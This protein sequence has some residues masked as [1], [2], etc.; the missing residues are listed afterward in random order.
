MS[1][2]KVTIGHQINFGFGAILMLALLTIF[3]V[4]EWV[5]KP[6]LIQQ[7]QQQ[8]A[9]A[10]AGLNDLLSSNLRQVEMLTSTLA[11]ASAQLPQ[12]EALFKQLFPGVLSNHGDSMIAGGGIWPEPNQ[13]TAGVERR[14]FFWGRSG[15]QML[16]FDGYNRPDGRGYHNESWYRVGRD[17]PV[18]RC[19]WS[20]PYIDPF[21]KTP[22]LTCT[23]PFSRD[24]R[25]AGVATVDMMLS[26]IAGLLEQYGRE[27]GGYAF[28]LDTTGKLIS[29]PHDRAQVIAPDNALMTSSELGR[30]LPW[31]KAVLESAT[32][33]QQDELIELKAD[34]ILG[35]AA[36]VN[37]I[38]QPKTGWTIGLVVPQSRMTGVA[39]SMGLFLMFAVGSLLL[40]VSV[41]GALFFR[42]LL[43][44][45]QQTT[46]Q[47]RE[48]TQGGTAQ[49]LEPGAM[50]EIGDLRQ[51]V[52]AYGDKLKAL[53]R[54]LERVKDELVQSEK[55]ASLGSLVSGVAHELNTPIGNALMSS[56]SIIDASRTISRDIEQQSMTRSALTNYTKDVCEG[57]EIIERN[58]ARAA[59]L[60]GAF[61][62][63]A[64]D[65][66]GSN[67]RQFELFGLINEIQL[68]M[69]P[70]LQ[71]SPFHLIMDVP[72]G[73]QLDSYPGKLSQV[74]INL[75]NNAIV[76]GFAERD[77]GRIQIT[78]TSDDDDW[79]LIDVTDDGRGIPAD[80]QKRIF[81][82]FFTTR[83]GQGGSG[84]GL[85][86]TFN[87]VAG[88]LGGSIEV[89]S[90]EG[91][92][93]C[94]RVR[95]PKEAP[96]GPAIN[97][98]SNRDPRSGADLWFDRDAMY[99][100]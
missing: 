16:Y 58:M 1:T 29:F 81:D 82:P 43:K 28:A 83:L 87:L 90:E 15:D 75:I 69:K 11:S 44:K 6:R 59:E 100:P 23:V 78:A 66:T 12:E 68:S 85:H 9:F 91:S 92:G 96:S 5:V 47:I 72:R 51:A 2:P 8:I 21:T 17:S 50:N 38:R 10:Q 55:L 31:L 61:K 52:N 63:L 26:G 89:I 19:N 53:L 56:T 71:R 36:Y 18:D 39:Q 45:V 34:A 54:H 30:Q 77:Q 80:L 42:N 22:M 88:I 7:Q 70:T 13:F 27:H 40:L 84:L 98:E 33:L 73:L 67:R 65:Q 35:E 60:I 57:A 49:A 3:A 41:L 24:N 94:F 48:L 32:E 64:V 4:V 99:V 76:H 86:I 37:L 79:V 25:F 74:L 62:Q 46:Q 93:S 14:S 97:A 20:A 95:L